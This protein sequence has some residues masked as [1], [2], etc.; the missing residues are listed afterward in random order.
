MIFILNLIFVN[1]LYYTY[2]MKDKSVILIT[3]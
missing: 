1:A 2:C 3:D